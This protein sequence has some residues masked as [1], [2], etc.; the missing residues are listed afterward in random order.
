[1]R[2]P[3]DS[4][5]IARGSFGGVLVMQ[6]ELPIVEPLWRIKLARVAVLYPDTRRRVGW[7]LVSGLRRCLIDVPENI[8]RDEYIDV[9]CRDDAILDVDVDVTLAGVAIFARA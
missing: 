4:D 8:G 3:Y 7:V 6:L 9:R 5:A 2:V 1:S